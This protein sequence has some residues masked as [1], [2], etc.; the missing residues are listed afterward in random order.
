MKRGN[1]WRKLYMGSLPAVF[2]MMFASGASGAE[3]AV[4]SGGATE[5]G[6]NYVA[7]AFQK[8]TGHAVRITY[9]TPARGLKRMAAGEV[10][11]VVAGSAES[12]RDVYRPAGKVEEGELP[13][14]RVGIGVMIRP[15]APVP[16]IS[17]VEA[18]KRAVLEADSVL[19][20]T[21]TS[22]QYIAGMLKTLGILV[23]A[24]AKA[25][26]LDTGPLTMDY[27]LNGKGK[28]FAFGP[29]TEIMTY[30]EKGLVLVGPLPEEVQH[31]Y[32]QVAVPTKNSTNKEVAWEFARF[33]AGPGKSIL[34]AYGIN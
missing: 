2:M 23:Q 9:D 29:I 30:K 25:R 3:I 22:G 27:V 11:D 8:A 7:A 13:M 33:C 34:A 5:P 15:G 16:D 18:L 4:L 10:F 24:E 28:E 12:V 31:Y 26:R 20:N 32:V 19:Y 17:S 6:L 21:A 1:Y 14:G